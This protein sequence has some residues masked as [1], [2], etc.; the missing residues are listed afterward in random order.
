LGIEIGTYQ[1]NYHYQFETKRT[2]TQIDTLIKSTNFKFDHQEVLKLV[3]VEENIKILSINFPLDFVYRY[4]KWEFMGGAK[5]FYNLEY[6]NDIL[7]EFRTNNWEKVES[8]LSASI[9]TIRWFKNIGIGVQYSQK[10]YSDHD[11]FSD[12]FNNKTRQ[13][14]VSFQYR[15]DEKKRDLED[16]IE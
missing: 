15:F 3:D 12:L 1:I 16:E 4:K 11:Y 6:S 7:S 9:G 5:I 2:I 14:G 13:F 8:G 10:V